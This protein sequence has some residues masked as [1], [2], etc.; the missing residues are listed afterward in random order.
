ME[1]MWEG[2]LGYGNGMGGLF[3]EIAALKEAVARA[4][5]KAA[6]HHPKHDFPSFC[7]Y[8]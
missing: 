3:G 2:V 6:V 7:V 1:E 4:I 8:G 5:D